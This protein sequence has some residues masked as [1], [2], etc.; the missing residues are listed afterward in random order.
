MKKAFT[1]AIVG[2]LGLGAAALAV[3]AAMSTMN[4]V[5]TQDAS[6]EITPDGM[7]YNGFTAAWNPIVGGFDMEFTLP[8]T[9]YYYDENGSYTRV[10]LTTI[11]KA[12]LLMQGANWDDPKIEVETFENLEPGSVLKYTHAV[13]EKGR[14]YYYYLNIYVGEKKDSDYPTSLYAGEAKSLP[15]APSDIEYVTTNGQ[16]PVTISF[17]APSTF[18]GTEYPLEQNI[19]KIVLYTSE[20]DYTKYENVVTEWASVTDIEPGSKQQFVITDDLDAKTYY[21][22][23]KATAYDGDSEDVSVNVLIGKDSPAAPKNVVAKE[24]ADGNVL[25]TWD[26]VT[27]GSQGGYFLPEEVT[28]TVQRATS[29]YGQ[30][31]ILKEGLTE[32]SYTFDTSALTDPTELFLSVAAVTE[33]GSATASAPSLIAGPA[34]S[35]P[36]VETFNNNGAADKLW[37]FNCIDSQYTRAGV[38]T[39]GVYVGGS[40]R[41]PIGG[42]GGMLQLGYYSS[43]KG[44]TSYYTSAKINVEGMSELNLTFNLLRIPTSTGV[45]NA[46]IAFDGGE[47]ATVVTGDMTDGDAIECVKH[48][49][50]VQVPDGAKNAIIRF[51]MLAGDTPDNICLDEISLRESG[52]AVAPYPASASDLKAVYDFDNNTILV[53][54]KAPE[55]THPTLGEANNQPLEYITR[56]DLLRQIGYG[57]YALVNSWD[58]PEVGAELS[59]TDTDLATG[60]EYRYKVV[61]Y[62]DTNSD[63]GAFMDESVMVGQIPADVTDLKATTAAGK[64]PVTLTFTAPLEDNRGEALR[65]ISAVKVYR[66]MSSEYTFVNVVDEITDVK[67]GQQLTA[68]DEDAQENY[69]YNYKVVAV[70]SAGESYGSQVSVY[71]GL[72]TPSKPTD[73]TAKVNDDNTITV[74]WTAPAGGINN[75]FVDLDNLTYTILLGAPNS[76]YEYYATELESGITGTSYTYTLESDQEQIYRFFVKPNNN[77]TSGESGISNSVIAGKPATLPYVEKFNTKVND[78]NLTYNNVWVATSEGSSDKIECAEQAYMPG[79][80]GSVV[81]VNADGGLAYV[82]YGTYSDSEMDQYITSGNIDVSDAELPVV[83]FY[84]YAVAG[85][86]TELELS[87]SFDGGEFWTFWGEN[88]RDHMGEDGWQKVEIPV[89][90]QMMQAKTIQLQF[91]AH[92]GAYACSAVIDDVTVFDLKAPKLEAN[93][94][95]LAWTV[96]PN[97]FAEL[98]GFQLFNVTED[99]D[100]MHSSHDA[101]AASHDVEEGKYYITALY[102]DYLESLPSNEVEV[103]L[104]GVGSAVAAGVTVKAIAGNIVVAGAEGLH[105]AIASTD[106]RV[107]HSAVGDATV[108]VV[109]GIY[110]VTVADNTVKLN[111]R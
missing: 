35:M 28:Y 16:A 96:E 14:A 3:P 86:D 74:T 104:Q 80:I 37:S 30:P 12:V 40:Q 18:A 23:L 57:D 111:V 56:I 92:K 75:G 103:S 45:V 31:E 19:D 89:D 76:E 32:C 99:G 25:I 70:G 65:E 26:A 77:G 7:S 72:D 2:A 64:A 34:S 21:F 84:Y 60:G 39:Y 79:N 82:Y 54:F 55:L 68:V 33:A 93:G 43:N 22:R 44:F 36:F 9:G 61:V 1:L 49:G 27:T 13:P 48:T 88:F 69:F 8:T 106:G 101:A 47:F 6:P 90:A 53:T 5:Q 67:P 41:L 85:Y 59:F 102:G 81:P 78:W 62:V 17:T 91:H 94:K 38:N 10:N 11:T 46:Q 109:P 108:S 100:E 4:T 105:V 107:L 29:T 24:L 58:N 83:S 95:T 97:E 71:L 87:V 50:S 63:F 15:S 66:K 51:E 20:Y 98:T 110:L 42:E 73:V 52:V